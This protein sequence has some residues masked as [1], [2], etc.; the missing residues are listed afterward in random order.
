MGALATLGLGVSTRLPYGIDMGIWAAAGLTDAIPVRT[1]N[2]AVTGAAIDAMTLATP[3]AGFGYGLIAEGL[4]EPKDDG[5]IL[6]IFSTGAYAHTLTTAANKINGNKHIA[7]FGGAVGDY[8]RLIA[9]NGIWY[10]LD[11]N[12][13]T[14]S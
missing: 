4:G 14:L 2:I 11:S 3:V 7:T 5:K 8:I 6:L 9:Y 10:V 13:V 12:G 1:G